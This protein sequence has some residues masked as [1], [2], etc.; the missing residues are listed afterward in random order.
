MLLAILSTT[1]LALGVYATSAYNFSTDELSKTFKDF[2]TSKTKVKLL[3][4]QNPSQFF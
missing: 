3:S 4:R 1:I 2:S